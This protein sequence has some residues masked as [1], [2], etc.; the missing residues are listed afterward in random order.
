[1]Q[2]LR[3]ELRLVS[4]QAILVSVGAPNCPK[5]SPALGWFGRLGAYPALF[6][7]AMQKD[8]RVQKLVYSVVPVSSTTSLLWGS[9]LGPLC[10]SI[11]LFAYCESHSVSS[12]LGALVTGNNSRTFLA[13]MDLWRACKLGLVQTY[14]WVSFRRCS[15]NVFNHRTG[16]HVSYPAPLQR[17]IQLFSPSY[18]TKKSLCTGHFPL[19]QA[20]CL[21]C[22]PCTS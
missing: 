11:L 22:T 16:H 10:V 21:C 4:L 2:L 17:L 1:M 15:R 14:V 9:S 5:A 12:L 13:H 8:D 3:T 18:S 7:W 20:V 6:F 19:C